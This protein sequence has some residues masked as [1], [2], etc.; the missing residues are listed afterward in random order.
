MYE[1]DYH[2]DVRGLEGSGAAGGLAGGLAALGATLVPGFD[3]VA[4]ALQLA[5]RIAHARLV[6]TGEGFLDEQ[7]FRGKAVGGVTELARAAGVPV[8]VVA[9]DVYVDDLP[10]HVEVV[11]LVDRFGDDRART[12]VLACVETVVRERLSRAEG[13]GR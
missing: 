2:V 7:S 12:E 9:G 10:D 8:L 11:S 1:R 13:G 5:E 3:V 6:V 4:D